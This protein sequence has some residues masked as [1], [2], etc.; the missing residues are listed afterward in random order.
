MSEPIPCSRHELGEEEVRA[1]T[2]VLRDGRLAGGPRMLM[3]EE[4]CESRLSASHALA[5]SSGGA[6]LEI[7]LRGLGI[8]PGHEVVVPTLARVDTAMAVLRIGAVPVFCDVDP[9]T[10]CVTYETVD[11]VW[12]VRTRAVI[13]VDFAGVPHDVFSLRR[14]CDVRGAVLVEDATHAFGA[15]QT[16][17]TPVGRDMGAHVT[18]FG[19]DPTTSITTAAGGLVTCAD[20]EVA[21][22]MRRIRNGG[23]TREFDS[24]RGLFD[25]LATGVG[26]DYTLN[27]LSA[28]LGLVQIDRLEELLERRWTAWDVLLESLA[29]L[30]GELEFP[31]HPTG[32]SHNLFV[33][34]LA[35][36]SV[37][38]ARRNGILEYLCE[39][40]VLAGFHYPLLHRQPVFA[41]HEAPADLAVA[42]R[43][44]RRALTLP[45]FPSITSEEIERTARTLSAA[46][47]AVPAED[48]STHAA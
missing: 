13:A 19:F 17:R 1:V 16:D 31:D 32:S 28:A 24:S 40:G 47:D 21:E 22:R 5:T 12:S 41:S 3:F 37:T 10:Y 36:D 33:V 45:L 42:Q 48:L 34:L 15:R 25:Y 14:L 44:E 30:Q 23:I 35:G 38:S 11:A 39:R 9:D 46:L 6:A 2:E 29:R 8:G 27:E 18:A 4:A 26:N 7:A 20:R 43:Y